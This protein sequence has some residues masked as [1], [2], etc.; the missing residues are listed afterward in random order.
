MVSIVYILLTARRASTIEH[1]FQELERVD[2]RLLSQIRVDIQHGGAVNDRTL[3]LMYYLHMNATI[4]SRLTEKV[5]A[6]LTKEVAR[7]T[8]ANFRFAM[9]AG[10]AIVFLNSDIKHTRWNH[11]AGTTQKLRQKID[12]LPIDV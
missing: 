10:H 4:L 3:Q 5:D 11:L 1:K 7:L 8:E 9:D 12:N 2:E 6:K